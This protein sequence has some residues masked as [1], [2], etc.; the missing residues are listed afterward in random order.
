MHLK[1]DVRGAGDEPEPFGV[2][3]AAADRVGRP[4]EPAR[5]AHA[6]PV[7]QRAA[8]CVYCCTSVLAFTG[9][10]R[11]SSCHHVLRAL[12]GSGS[13]QQDA[14][15]KRWNTRM[16][17]LL[18]HLG[19]PALSKDKDYWVRV[20]CLGFMIRGSDHCAPSVQAQC[21]RCGPRP[22]R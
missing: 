3:R 12:D 14:H 18:P 1:R 11:V 10:T 21:R 22:A 17:P 8:G 4:A 6:G 19:S 20:R 9:K 2:E 7:R 13:G 16:A 15:T 5:A